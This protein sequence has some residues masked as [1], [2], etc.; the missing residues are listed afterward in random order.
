LQEL[1][2]HVLRE[3]KVSYP[4]RLRLKEVEV[5]KAREYDEWW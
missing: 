3:A 4:I 1:N 5:S 2:L